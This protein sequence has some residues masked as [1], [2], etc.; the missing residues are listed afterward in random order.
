MIGKKINILGVIV[1]VISIIVTI[2]ALSNNEK[3]TVSN[4]NNSGYI[5]NQKG[6]NNPAIINNRGNI[7]INKELK[8]KPKIY[9][10]TIKNNN[11]VKNLNKF[12]DNNKGKIVYL[13]IY[14]MPKENSIYVREKTL[15]L[16]DDPA[17]IGDFDEIKGGWC[18]ARFYEFKG[19]HYRNDVS[20]SDIYF[21]VIGYFIVPIDSDY[22]EGNNYYSL[23][24][25]SSERAVS[26]K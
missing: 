19:S 15:I 21:S 17:C 16:H 6:D 7:N 20:P 24:S 4:D 5:V 23:E 3:A 12:I 2:I 25:V 9:D 10:D 22:Y 8:E 14:V 1:G 11:Q 26:G 13:R 18:G